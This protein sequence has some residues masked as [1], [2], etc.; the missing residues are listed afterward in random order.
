MGDGAANIDLGWESFKGSIGKFLQAIFGF[1]GTV[2]FARMLGP[3]SFGGFYFLLSIL[4]IC[5]RPLRG[6]GGALH[7]RFAE[8]DATKRELV[9][10][11]LLI[12]L[13]FSVVIL[14]TII[15]LHGRL[16][17]ATNVPSAGV[18]FFV[19][20]VAM[21]VFFPYQMLLGAA[22][23]PARQT[24]NDTLRSLL[25]FPLQ[26][27]FVLAGFGA[28]GMGYGLAAATL[29]TAVT[30]WWSVRVVPAV[31]TLDTLGSL[32]EFA[33]YNIPSNLLGKAYDEFDSILL[34][35]MITTAVVGEYQAAFKLTLPA[36]FIG[37]VIVSGLVPKVSNL[38]SR[39]EAATDD[40]QNVIAYSSILAVPI[41]FGALAISEQLIVTA[42]GGKYRDGAILLI[43]LA[44]YRL[45]ETQR[46]IFDG[47]F[48]GLDRPSVVMK[49]DAFALALNIVVGVV[50]VYVMGA[51]GVVIAT[52]L[53]EVSRYV[54]LAVLIRDYVEGVTLVPRPLQEQLVAGVVMF[55]AVELSARFVGAS[56]WLNTAVLVGL[57]GV[58]Y[59]GILLVISTNFRVTIRSLYEDS[60]VRL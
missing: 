31:P 11:T 2:V 36:A 29:L 30:A 14:V 51:V 8:A 37:T 46:L 54:I 27:G 44:L 7:K 22:G 12:N 60:G 20:F 13:V 56:T 59:V 40:I 55:V 10:A 6:V 17:S 33:K 53:A 25:T 21:A 4:Y 43:G 24:W 52:V 58:V 18:V 41:F 1:A 38:S 26:I 32:W 15:A 35:A 57:G 45:F 19:L 39:G 16:E 34:G 48:K 47:T 3:A 49:I 5:D 42:Y 9:G 23:M 28:A 50:L